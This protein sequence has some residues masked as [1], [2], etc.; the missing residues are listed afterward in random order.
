MKKFMIGVVLLCALPACIKRKKAQ[1]KAEPETIVIKQS[2]DA[3]ATASGMPVEGMVLQKETE[4]DLF[5]EEIVNEGTSAKARAAQKKDEL[6]WAEI[7]VET[8]H[9]A[10]VVQFEFDKY[11]VRPDQRPKIK[12][13]AEIVKDATKEGA[14]V[15]VEG[16]ACHISK[17][18]VYNYKL[19]EKRAQEVVDEYEAAGVDTSNIEVVGRG[20]SMALTD[21]RGEQWRN[22]RVNTNVIYKEKRPARTA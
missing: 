8:D 9:D 10:D 4:Y 19:S 20:D 5:N 3:R 15:V 16:H 2:A 12:R 18:K 1:P 22:R 17:S 11:E 7:D 21:D 13:N 14:E 6:S